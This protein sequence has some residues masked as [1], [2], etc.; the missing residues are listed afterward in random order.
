MTL[1][2][3]TV[4]DLVSGARDLK[5]W[6]LGPSGNNL[7]QVQASTLGKLVWKPKESLFKEHSSLNRAP[8]QAPWSFCGVCSARSFRLQS[9][10]QLRPATRRATPFPSSLMSVLLANRLT[11]RTRILYTDSNS[12]HSVR[13]TWKPVPVLNTA[14]TICDIDGDTHISYPEGPST[15][16]FEV[17]GPKNHTLNGIW[18]LTPSLYIKHIHIYICIHY[19]CVYIYMYIPNTILLMVLEPDTSHIGYSNPLGNL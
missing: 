3:S 12:G 6:V 8:F 16:I 10:S 4:K 9:H 17:S 1:V 14:S 19:M 2:P 18:N 13:A 15:E 7:C 11:H 5:Y